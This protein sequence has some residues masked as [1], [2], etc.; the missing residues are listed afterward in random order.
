MDTKTENFVGYNP[1]KLSSLPIL[2]PGTK[3][4]AKITKIE[5]GELKEFITDP[6]KL[7]KWV[8]CDP[9]DHFIRVFAESDSGH[10]IT[11]LI[12]LRNDN[13]VHPRS[14]LAKWKL[15]Y[16]DYPRISQQV[17]LVVDDSNNLQFML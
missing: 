2:K 13:L 15:L 10:V 6:E 7:D 16:G 14:N 9:S 17:E 8:N 3:L 5:T 1:D 4:K 11:K 12:Y